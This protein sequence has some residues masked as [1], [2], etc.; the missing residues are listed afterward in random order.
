MRWLWIAVFGFGAV[1]AAP[2]SIRPQPPVC[3]PV[4]GS[5]RTW[6]TRVF[7]I[8]SEIQVAPDRLQRLAQVADTTAQAVRDHPLPF[9][10][11]PENDRPVLR[12]YGTVESYAAAGAMAETAG[13]YLWK[14]REVA[15]NAVHLF[16]KI[17]GSRLGPL[18]DEDLVVHEIVHLCMHGSQ[19]RMPQWFSEG[20]CEYFAAAHRGAGRFQ[21]T[22]I[23]REIRLL[24]K[25]RLAPDGGATELLAIREVAGLGSRD[26]ST[27]MLRLQP[28]DRYRGYATGLL[29]FHYHLH[30]ERFDD[31]KI[32]LKRQPPAPPE[33]FEEL[34]N[35]APQLERGLV[36]F[37]KGHGLGVR[38]TVP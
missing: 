14:R 13:C 23:E 9:Y 21:F 10:A 17:P 3:E 15:L 29:L 38:F 2:P 5:E 25:K 24:L 27:K 16:Q 7:R 8:E 34:P 12:I 19:G 20:A 11:P 35:E 30:G 31:L 36:E 33:S 26:W 32:A 6:N 4:P 37:W 1:S 22:D 28:E 18:T